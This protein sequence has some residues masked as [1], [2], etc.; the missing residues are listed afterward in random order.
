MTLT[1]GMYGNPADNRSSQMN[2]EDAIACLKA[3]GY[4]VTK[5]GKSRRSTKDRVGPTF[6]ANF[7][8]GRVTRMSCCCS[9][10]KPDWNRGRALA[11]AAICQRHR[12]QQ[13][14]SPTIP[15]IIDSWF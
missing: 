6:V 14:D 12:D 8:D 15:V 9:D 2:L 5:P 13:I 10:E 3:N 4:R 1:G 7:S 11:I